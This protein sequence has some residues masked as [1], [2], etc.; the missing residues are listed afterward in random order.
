M[1]YEVRRQVKP[2]NQRILN[3]I[4]HMWHVISDSENDC[5]LAPPPGHK[6]K[7]STLRP[8]HTKPQ[9][10]A[11]ASQPPRSLTA[12]T[13][14]VF[15]LPAFTQVDSKWKKIFIPSLYNVSLSVKNGLVSE[16]T[17]FRNLKHFMH[18]EYE[19]RDIK[20]WCWW[21]KQVDGRPWANVLWKTDTSNMHIR[22]NKDYIVCT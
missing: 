20:V 4:C 13:V 19:P 2:S 5:E 16:L 14:Q 1:I 22:Q 6:L 11:G 18:L 3:H 21:A 15:H 7:Q 12:N 10:Q 8:T 17:P 9:L